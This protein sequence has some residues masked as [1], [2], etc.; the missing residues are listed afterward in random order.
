MIDLLFCAHNRLEFTKIALTCMFR[1]TNWSL[2]RSVHVYDDDSEDGTAEYLR[3][4][5]E[6][7]TATISSGEAPWHFHARVFGGP[8]AIMKDFLAEV[9]PIL[10]AK[11]DNDTCV[12][13]M[14]LDCLNRTLEDNPQLDLLGMEAMTA[15]AN[16]DYRED[17]TEGP[18]GIQDARHIGGIGLMRGRAFMTL[19]EPR[20]DH[21]RFGFTEW[22]HANPGV[23]KAWLDPSLPV[24]LLDHV[25]DEPFRTLS[26]NYFQRHWQRVWPKY[27]SDWEWWD[28]IEEICA[29]VIQSQPR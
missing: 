1:H 18:R 9:K 13:E 8:V 17:W 28:W 2:V 25:P 5:C 21:G 3:W 15:I 4:C 26:E 22:Q 23:K 11:I 14:W 16:Y 10:F 24:V 7:Q 6:R 29:D 12:P 20:G 19:P 27:S